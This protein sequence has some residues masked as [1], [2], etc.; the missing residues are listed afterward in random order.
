MADEE[1]K[2]LQMVDLLLSQ[3]AEQQ[4]LCENHRGQTPLHVAVEHRMVAALIQRLVTGKCVQRRNGFLLGF[5]SH[6]IIWA[7]S[8][9]LFSGRV[10]IRGWVYASHDGHS[11]RCSH[12]C[13]VAAGANRSLHDTDA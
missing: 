12:D 3:G 6:N 8:L 1:E 7:I 2:R 9:S 11:R 5:P 10:S 13:L 4:L